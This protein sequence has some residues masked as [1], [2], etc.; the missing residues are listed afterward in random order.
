MEFN[1]LHTEAERRFRVSSDQGTVNF[2]V[3]RY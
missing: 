3:I 2:E 1:L